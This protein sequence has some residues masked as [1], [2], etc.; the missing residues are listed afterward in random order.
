METGFCEPVGCCFL[1]EVNGQAMANS[2]GIDPE[3]CIETTG[4]IC[5]GIGGIYKGNDTDCAEF[6]ECA[7]PPPPTIP[8]LSEWGLIIMA[9]ILGII[10][11]IMVIRRRRVTA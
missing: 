7:L 2:R 6:P 8:T 5:G 1:E 10:G 11:F 3:K 4:T 9:G